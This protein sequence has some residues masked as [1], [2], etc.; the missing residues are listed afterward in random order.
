MLAIDCANANHIFRLP[1]SKWWIFSLAHIVY[2][3]INIS[4]RLCL[5]RYEGTI[6]FCDF[7]IASSCLCRVCC[8]YRIYSI[9]GG[10]RE[11]SNIISNIIHARVARM[12]VSLMQIIYSRFLSAH[13]RRALHMFRRV[14]RRLPARASQKW[15]IFQCRPWFLTF[16]HVFSLCAALDNAPINLSC[17]DLDRHRNTKQTHINILMGNGKMKKTSE[18]QFLRFL[19]SQN[20]CK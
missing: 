14:V 1:E 11:T 17:L 3:I 8:V 7:F 4:H 5:A 19:C 15:L 2:S 16:S 18:K 13:R 9:C 6:G 12:D 20:S 10:A